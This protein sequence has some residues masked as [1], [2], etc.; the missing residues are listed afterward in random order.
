MRRVV[1][2]NQGF[3]EASEIYDFEPRR[4]PPSRARRSRSLCRRIVVAALAALL[5]GA[6]LALRHPQ[7][8]SPGADA[9]LNPVPSPLWLAVAKPQPLF[10][11]ADPDLA[12]E[13]RSYEVRA[14]RTG[15]GRQDILVFGDAN[16][17]GPLVRLILYRAGSEAAPTAAFFVELA[18]RAAETGRAITFAAQPTA[19]PTR[20]G[21]FE[22]ADLS[23]SQFSLNRSGDGDAACIGFRTANAAAPATNLRIAGFTCGGKA[24]GARILTKPDLACLIDAIELLPDVDDNDLAAFFAGRELNDATACAKAVSENGL[25]QLRPKMP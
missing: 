13:P 19:L 23:M 2:E 8:G 18:R 11:L 15:G 22:A 21:V 4:L 25:R 20:L 16:G 9:T 24:D 12:P 1:W 3:A 10:A 7:D 14:H 5:F 6:V 17:A